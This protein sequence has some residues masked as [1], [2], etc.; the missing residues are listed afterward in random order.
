MKSR[1]RRRRREGRV[2]QDEPFEL[3]PVT[4]RHAA[5]RADISVQLLADHPDAMGELE[6]WFIREW[7]PY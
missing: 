5:Q 4:S 2:T 3:R 1:R 7:E 6:R